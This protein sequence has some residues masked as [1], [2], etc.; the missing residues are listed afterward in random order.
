MESLA[1]FRLGAATIQAMSF[2]KVELDRPRFSPKRLGLAWPKYAVHPAPQTR[3]DAERFL[4][5][6]VN[7]GV[8]RLGPLLLES[9]S[10]LRPPETLY[11]RCCAELFNLIIANLPFRICANEFCGNPFTR[12]EGSSRYGGHRTD[13]LRYCSPSCAQAQAQREYRRRKKLAPEGRSRNRT[14]GGK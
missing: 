1:E 10:V 4:H 7:L 12:Q 13:K 2:A 5:D 14:K 8:A 6:S 3:D 9:A 11:A